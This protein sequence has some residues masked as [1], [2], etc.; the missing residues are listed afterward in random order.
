MGAI[1]V[2]ADFSQAVIA[3]ADFRGADTSGARLDDTVA[4][5]LRIDLSARGGTPCEP[6][7]G[8][9]RALPPDAGPPTSI[10]P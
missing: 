9:R 4:R 10:S 2:D 6:A 8:R 1:A 3:G 7:R 5:R